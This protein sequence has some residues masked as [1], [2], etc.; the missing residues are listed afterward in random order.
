M[1]E[2]VF[3]RD[4]E[5]TLTDGIMADST[6]HRKSGLWAIDSVNGNSWTGGSKYLEFTGAD[7]VCFQETKLKE[8]D[9]IRS[10]EDT[11]GRMGWKL[12]MS[13]AA[14]GERGGASAGVGITVR[15][16]LGLAHS[17]LECELG[18]ESRFLFRKLGAVRNGG[19][20]FG[21]VYLHDVVGPSDPKN[22]DILEKIAFHLK[23]VAGSWA[24][25][26]NW[27]CTPEE[28]KATGWLKL[29]GA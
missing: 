27:N 5:H 12:S 11:A 1:R 14:S 9:S 23:S 8:E 22:K 28:L 26:G 7:A 21:S 25:A 4:G 10:A 20:H 29:I 19:L 2:Q 24:L 6:I 3:K 18:I 17:D 13:K 16:H 15:K